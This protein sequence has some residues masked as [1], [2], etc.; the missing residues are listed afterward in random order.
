M[1]STGFL[2][3]SFVLSTIFSPISF[4]LSIILA[5]A[6]LISPKVFVGTALILF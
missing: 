6:C 3:I 5:H 1:Y 4:V 2:T